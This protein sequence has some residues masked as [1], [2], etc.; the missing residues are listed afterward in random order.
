MTK[1]VS[2]DPY[3]RSAPVV[4]YLEQIDILRLTPKHPE[5]TKIQDGW[6]E[7]IQ[8]VLA[9]TASPKEALDIVQQRLMK[10]LVDPN[11]PSA[12]PEKP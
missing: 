12:G 10:E 2:D 3:Y 5:W 7:A 4:N 1:A 9:G 8:M 11:L 6:G